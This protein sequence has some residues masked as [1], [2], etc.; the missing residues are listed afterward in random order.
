MK[1]LYF[2]N[3][4]NL[5]IGQLFFYLGIFFLPSALSISALLL[6]ISSILGFFNQKG[7]YLQDK[8]NIPFFVAGI[9]LII[10]TVFNAV[11]SNGLSN[12]EELKN[13]YTYIGLFN[14]IPFIF[15]FYGFQ[16][17]L[18]SDELRK[19]CSY[20]FLAGTIPVIFSIIG[21]A[22]LGLNGPF[23]TLNG[24][25]VW[26]QR[27]VNSIFGITG[28][29][30]NPNYLGSWLTIV[31]PFCLAAFIYKNKTKFSKLFCL[32]LIIIIALAMFF[33]AS[34]A[35]WL[36]LILSVP[37]LIGFKKIKFFVAFLIGFMTMLITILF[38]FSINNF[39][40]LI[41]KFIPVEIWTNF[42]FTSTSNH[43]S[44]LNIWQNAISLIFKNPFMGSGFSTFPDY[45]KS[46]TGILIGHTHNIILEL[47]VSYGIPAAIFIILPFSL[48]V[49]KSYTKIFLKNKLSFDQNIFNKAWITSLILL[50]LINL[51]DM[52][53]FDARISIGGWI[54][55]AGARN[56][57][58]YS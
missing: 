34:R 54:L 35:A 15:S 28:L 46:E 4:F 55:L 23:E 50:A 12:F 47:M 27:P 52:T 49:Q 53:Y 24:L 45:L 38:S 8:L 43:I 17:Y 3:K 32:I 21:Q 41:Q 51:V 5:K 11:S 36:S 29:F 6:L 22:F 20:L 19:N 18:N 2:K 57:I 42:S 58:R 37:L 10:S 14:W 40:L 44:R 39:Q 9:L 16:S 26:Y 31:W 56:I 1:F 30:N 48:I 7:N 33:C 13:I 25:I